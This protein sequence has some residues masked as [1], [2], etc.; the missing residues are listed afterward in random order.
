MLETFRYYKKPR[1][2]PFTYSKGVSTLPLSE[3]SV[4][5]TEIL[6]M[7]DACGKNVVLV[8]GAAGT[9]KTHLLQKL[10]NH[11]VKVCRVVT[12]VTAP[13]GVAAIN[14]G[15]NT[16]HSWLGVG[17]GH[18]P[19]LKLLQRMSA[20]CKRQIRATQVLIIDEVSMLGA[21]L[22]VKLHL[23]TQQ[24][25]QS[26]APF[27]GLRVLLFGDFLQL[28]PV[29]SP[30]FIF[31][32]DLWKIQLNVKR[33]HLRHVYRQNGDAQFTNLLH[34]VRVARLDKDQLALLVTRQVEPPPGITPTRLCVFRRVA[35][36]YN[37]KKLTEL[38]GPMYNK[39]AIVFA[40]KRRYED[41]ANPEDL[42][43]AREWIKNWL[44][45]TSTNMFPVNRHFRVKVGAYVMLRTNLDVE[46][47]LVNGTCLKVV[48]IWPDSI[49]LYH[50]STKK[51]VTVERV[52]FEYCVN[53]SVSAILRQFPLSLA[54]ATTIHKSQGLTLESA[55]ID[56]N[57]FAPGQ[58]YCALS[59]VKRLTDLYLTKWHPEGLRIHPR[60]CDF[61]V[62]GRFLVVLLACTVSRPKPE[63]SR[64][65]AEASTDDVRAVWTRV[66]EYM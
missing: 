38:S 26:A 1:T 60:A 39:S 27:G 40:Q 56:T 61:E 55:L 18:A 32:T 59:R 30:M 12:A 47:G 41:R 28:P 46:K 20:V 36:A 57:C 48:T 53:K 7:L 11:L 43:M 64:A 13:T 8:S 2:E 22:F 4:E 9:G 42:Q 52:D 50:P 63:I 66:L 51:T 24:V 34:S 49:R 19:T 14:I 54:W 6:R 37:D 62:D 58:V 3:R 25:R 45:G 21:D 10:R 5:F 65:F 31:D 33:I 29:E 17:T 16:L 44:A 23:L 15:G 35:D